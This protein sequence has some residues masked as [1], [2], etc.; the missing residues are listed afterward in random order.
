MPLLLL[1]AFTFIVGVAISAQLAEF[2]KGLG[3]AALVA[4]IILFYRTCMSWRERNF[5]DGPQCKKE[6]RQTG[7]E[8]GCSS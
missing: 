3:L 1:I 4:C 5:P 7:E 6:V 8:H 2:H